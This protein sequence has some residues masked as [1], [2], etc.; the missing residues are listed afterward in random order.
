MPRFKQVI[1]QKNAFKAENITLKEQL[2]EVDQIKGKAAKAEAFQTII[3]DLEAQGYTDAKSYIEAQQQIAADNALKSED[4]RQFNQRMDGAKQWYVTQV[5]TG[6][7]TPEEAESQWQHWGN[8]QLRQRAEAQR[9]AE[10]EKE[11]DGLRADR[12]RISI[13][14]KRN[15]AEQQIG[16][17]R[18]TYPEADLDD[19]REYFA[20]GKGDIPTLLKNSHEKALKLIDRGRAQALN[21]LSAANNAPPVTKAGSTPQSNPAATAPFKPG[22]GVS[23]WFKNGPMAPR[24]SV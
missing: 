15:N 12:E 13:A 4:Q 11:R 18:A 10:V 24:S 23:R 5:N 7:L 20:Q 6:A 16:Q 17:L 22:G 3:D 9:L 2:A 8:E 19:V 1:D 21:G 14:E